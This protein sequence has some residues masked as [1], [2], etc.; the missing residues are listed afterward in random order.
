ML[1]SPGGNVEFLISRRELEHARWGKKEEER[2]REV[3]GRLIRE[4]A[5]EFYTK[6][7]E[8]PLNKSRVSVLRV[9]WRLDLK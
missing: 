6:K 7:K 4:I 9:S 1:A 5:G 2:E 8:A 3:E